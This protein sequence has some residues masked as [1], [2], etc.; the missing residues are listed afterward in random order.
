[1]WWLATS[2]ASR[3]VPLNDITVLDPGMGSGTFLAEGAR[4]L[5]IAGVPNFWQKLTGFDIAAQVMGIAH[6]NLYMAVLSQLDHR[7]ALEVDDLRLY[8]T[9]TLDPRNGQYLKSILPLLT[10]SEDRQFIE[11]RI[12]VSARIKQPS[13]FHLVIGNPPYRNNSRLTLRQVT[14]RFPRLLTSSDAKAVRRSGTSVTT[15]HGFSRRRT[16]M[17]IPWGSSALSYPTP[18]RGFVATATFAR[19]YSSITACIGSFA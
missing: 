10:S 8:T 7:H 1:M 11:Q 14:Q 2:T 19:R 5:A 17:L 16:T 13:N 4:A 3:S 6:V 15:M 9:D 12:D 18:S